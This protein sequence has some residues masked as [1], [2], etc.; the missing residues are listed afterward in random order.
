MTQCLNPR[1]FRPHMARYSDIEI[2][3]HVFVLSAPLDST[4]G[5]LFQE[6]RSRLGSSDPPRTRT[7]T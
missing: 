6:A 3:I 4:D 1:F 7:E 5:E 2:P